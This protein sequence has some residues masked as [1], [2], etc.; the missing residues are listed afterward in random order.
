[1]P[2]GRHAL[3][4]ISQFTTYASGVYHIAYMV[5]ST[6]R[7][8]VCDDSAPERRGLAI[9]LRGAGYEVDEASDG[10]GAVECLK[11]SRIDLLL[12]DLQMP[13]GDGF[14]VLNYVHEHRQA[15]PVILLTGLP[16]DQIQDRMAALKRREL[17]PLFIKPVNP[18]ALLQVVEMQLSGELPPGGAAPHDPAQRIPGD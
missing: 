14:E 8:L 11:R 10:G 13:G 17:P 2:G 7:L 9:Y 3:T 12:L 6:P 15:L 4:V 18:D 1:M 5:A 16:P